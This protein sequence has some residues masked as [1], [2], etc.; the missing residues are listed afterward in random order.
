MQ[1]LDGL[2]PPVEPDE[3]DAGLR[4]RTLDG[5]RYLDVVQFGQGDEAAGGD[6]DILSVH[7]RPALLSLRHTSPR[8]A[9]APAAA[10]ARSSLG[11][12]CW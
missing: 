4:R 11:S 3:A 2:D 10:A 1:R 5:S 12:T 8:M 9:R 7:C 6:I